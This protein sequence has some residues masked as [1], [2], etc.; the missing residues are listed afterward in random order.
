M[1]EY[2]V[3]GR[4]VPPDQAAFAAK[5]TL[6]VN[7][8]DIDR[9][10]ESMSEEE[11]AEI[12]CGEANGRTRA[13]RVLPS[14]KIEYDGFKRSGGA[15]FPS[16]V[17]IACGFDADLAYAVGKEEGKECCACGVHLTARVPRLSAPKTDCGDRYRYLSESEKLTHELSRVC[18]RRA[19][20]GRGR[21]RTLRRR[22]GRTLSCSRGV[23]GKGIDFGKR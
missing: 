19:I 16:A 14:L 22:G 8:M 7:T 11:R 9:I 15:S 10:L 20:Y 21:K 23:Q 1:V 13:V 12:I 2:T 5:D 3:G 4:C 17:A 18:G 6:R